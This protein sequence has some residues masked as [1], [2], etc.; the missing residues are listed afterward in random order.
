M[1]NNYNELKTLDPLLDD[2]LE[3]M[4]DIAWAVA[5]AGNAKFVRSL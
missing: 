5:F 4:R 2:G 3:L 1:M